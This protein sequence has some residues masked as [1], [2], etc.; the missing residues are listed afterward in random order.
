MAETYKPIKEVTDQNN[1]CGVS[2]WHEN[3]ITGEGVNVWTCEH[4]TSHAETTARRVTDSAPNAKVYYGG[5]ETMRSNDEIYYFN[6]VDENGKE[7]EV[8]DFIK[9]NG[10]DICT[11]SMGSDFA[12]K[13]DGAWRKMWEELQK[14]YNLTMFNSSGNKASEEDNEEEGND[15]AMLV[16]ALTL[17]KGKVTPASYTSVT[18][19]V[20]FADFTGVWSGT[21][22]SSP[23]LAGKAALLLERY[24][25]MSQTEVFKYFKM[26]AQ[27]VYKQGEDDKTGWGL[28][29]LPKFS[30]KYIT[31]TT[32][33]NAYKINGNEYLMDTMPVNK[34][35]RVFVPIR[36][37]AEALG[38]EVNWSKNKDK[39]IKVLIDKGNV[40]I[41]LNT[42][43]DVAFIN[44]KKDILDF[45]PFIDKNNRTLVPIRFIAEAMNCKVDWIQKEAKVMILE[46]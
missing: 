32:K 9:A 40:H 34:E 18:E 13:N 16:G 43:S 8:N 4:N 28:V 38:A 23:Y 25:K 22:F 35:G 41:E 29:V 30:K 11:R 42:G 19:D 39:S 12:G 46:Q 14:K 3:G 37:I 5:F 24:G 36:V 20:D 10:I 26:C 44:G 33:S 31:M 27:D 1:Y 15:L 21:S 2:E 17:I 7:W 45:A 6:V